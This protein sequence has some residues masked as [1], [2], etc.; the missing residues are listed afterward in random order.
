[1]FS[2]SQ[3]VEEKIGEKAIPLDQYPSS[4]GEKQSRNNWSC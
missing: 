1:M 4:H 3:W 2:L